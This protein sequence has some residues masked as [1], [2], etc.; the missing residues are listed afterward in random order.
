MENIIRK[1]GMT[2]V[3]EEKMLKMR[4]QITMFKEMNIWGWK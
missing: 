3:C 1:V 4:V 2:R